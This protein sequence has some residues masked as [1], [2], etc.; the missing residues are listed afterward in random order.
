MT[1]PDWSIAGSI[2]SGPW[3]RHRGVLLLNLYLML[4]LLTSCINGYDSSIVNGLQILPSWKKQFHDP[5]G[6]TLGMISSAQMI[7]SLVVRSSFHSLFLRQ[8]WPTSTLFV[9]AVLMLGGVGLQAIASTI[10]QFIG[11]RVLVGAG[12]V[13]GLNAAPLLIIELAYPTQRGRITS[14]YNT[15]WY[16]GS[17][18]AAWTCFVASNWASTSVWSWRALTILQAIGPLLQIFLIW[19][20]PESPRWLIS[21]GR[22]RKALKIL[23]RFHAVGFDERDPLVLYEMAQIRQALKMDKVNNRGSFSSLFATPGNRKR[24]RLVIG[25]ALFSQW[26]GNGLISHYINLVLENVGV[27]STRTKATINGG[28]QVWNLAAALTGSLLVDKVGPRTLFIVSN[29]GMLMAFSVWVL[30]ISLFYTV[31]LTAAAKAAIP[32]IFMFYFF[33][34]LAYTPMLVAYTLEIL[35]FSIRAKG[36]AVMYLAY[37]AWLSFELAFVILFVVETRGR[38]LEETATLFDGERKSDSLIQTREE[39]T[40]ISMN[41][42][43]IRVEEQGGGYNHSKR[44]LPAEFYELRRPRPALERDRLSYNKGRNWALNTEDTEDRVEEQGSGYNRSKRVLPAEFYELRRPRHVLERDR[45]SYNKGRN[46][47]LNT[48][49]TEETLVS[50]HSGL[51]HK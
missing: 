50:A 13:F 25:V 5:R 44:V 47:A 26:S 34:G 29:A 11:A 9:G 8:V 46:W 21:K 43:P 42:D 22:E 30:T 41:R 15:S 16:G 51:S 31:A 18:V 10:T 28:L 3:W 14:L 38:T 24:M 35:P 49:Y 19:F 4:P 27:T 1:I 7:G 20:V 48:E 40:A 36:F 37:C 23:A 33:Y 2:H 45:L 32:F 12:L 6:G 39:A 17:I